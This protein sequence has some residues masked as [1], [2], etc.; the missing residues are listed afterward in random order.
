MGDDNDEIDTWLDKDSNS[1]AKTEAVK[2]RAENPDMDS[3]SDCDSLLSMAGVRDVSCRYL[4][5]L[6]RRQ[7]GD[8]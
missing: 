2:T 4:T 1:L 6:E 5:S 8:A 7:L 3:D